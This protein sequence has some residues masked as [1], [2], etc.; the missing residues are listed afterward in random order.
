MLNTYVTVEQSKARDIRAAYI[1]MRRMFPML[2]ASVCFNAIRPT[3]TVRRDD[4]GDD[5]RRDI[6]LVIALG[7]RDLMQCD[8]HAE[9]VAWCKANGYK[10]ADTSTSF[11]Y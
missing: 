11:N 2:S 8:T 7:N 4:I 10:L 5:D 3:V 9:C 6:V 1:S